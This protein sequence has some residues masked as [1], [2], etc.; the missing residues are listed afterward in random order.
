MSSKLMYR[1][2]VDGLRA[3]AVLAVMLFHADIPGFPGGFVGVDV[4]FVIS[5]YLITGILLRELDS[6]SFSIIAFYERRVRRILPA[7]FLVLLVC[8]PV[9]WF[10][11]APSALQRLGQ[12]LVAVTVFVSNILFWQTTNYFTATVENP[13]LHTWSLGVEEQFYIFFPLFLWCVWRYAR[14]WLGWAMVLVAVLSL[15]ISQWGVQSGRVTPAFYL[16][17]TR[18]FEL[19]LGALV[20]SAALRGRI[21]DP[22]ARISALLAWAGL[23]VIVWAVAMFSRDT[24]FPGW[25]ALAPSAGAAMVLAFAHADSLLGRLLSW[26]FMVGIGLISYSA[27]LW[28]QPVFAFTRIAGWRPG[29]PAN[30][31]LIVVSLSLAWLSWRYVEHPFRDRTRMS[32]RAVFGWAGVVSAGVLGV[33]TFLVATNGVASRYTPEELRWWRYSDIDLQSSYVTKRF[34][35]HGGAFASGSKRKVLILGDSFAQDFANMMHEAGA[36]KDAQVRTVYIPAACQMVDVSEDTH[37]HV[38]PIY[39]PLCARSSSIRSSISLIGQADIVVL[40]AK[41]K[42]WSVELLPKTIFNMHLRTDQ[43]LF[44]IG[45]KQFQHVNIRRLLA[46]GDAGRAERRSQV[47][48]DVSETN[49]LLEMSLSPNVFVDQIHIICG[50]DEKCPVVTDQDDLISYDGGHLTKAGA[51]YIGKKIFTESALASAR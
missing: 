3:V 51:E 11:M 13:L 16:S 20:A 10:V 6:G 18:A 14:R 31:G 42:Q 7:L 35:E 41:W 43:R 30:L 21:P 50:A 38:P 9:G 26:R 48:S 8:I 39:R 15:A 33:G 46:R 49:R 36:W 29:L 44:V 47:P 5:G 12:S 2:E 45:P 1:P 4:F 25:H 37:E 32:R 34:D 17:P 27:Y 23:G 40:A 19:L 28:H 22:G 24:P